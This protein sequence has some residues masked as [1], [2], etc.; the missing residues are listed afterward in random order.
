MRSTFCVHKAHN[1]PVA[2]SHFHEAAL[3]HVGGAPFTPQMW[4]KAKNDSSSGKSRSTR[5]TT[6]P[7]SRRQRTRERRNAASARRGWEPGRWLGRRLC[8]LTGALSPKYSA[9][10]APGRS[11]IRLQD[12]RELSLTECTS[13][14]LDTASC[15]LSP[16]SPSCRHSATERARSLEVAKQARHLDEQPITRPIE[17]ACRDL[18]APGA[19]NPYLPLLRNVLQLCCLAS[20]GNQI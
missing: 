17:S 5:R 18:M 10:C 8:P 11:S 1:R 7:Q 19:L 4:G 20:L 14:P 16:R 3:D 12:V 9:S 6:V 2:A 15:R 13:F